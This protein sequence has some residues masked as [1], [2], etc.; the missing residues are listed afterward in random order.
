MTTTIIKKH[1]VISLDEQYAIVNALAFY[2]AFHNQLLDADELEQF[3][4]AF[5]EDDHSAGV[6]DKLATRIANIH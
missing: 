5:K 6:I 2:D 3:K 1:L 4:L